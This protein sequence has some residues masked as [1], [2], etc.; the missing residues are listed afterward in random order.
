MHDSLRPIIILSLVSI[1]GA[2]VAF[3]FQS[4]FSRSIEATT[5]QAQRSA[6]QHVLPPGVQI[7]DAFGKNPL[8]PRYWIG[9]KDSATV[10]YAFPAETR[11]FSGAVNS[12]VG[13]D[14]AGI[15]LGVRLLASSGM[16]AQGMAVEDFIPKNSL[17][18]RM[19]GKK[20]AAETWFAEQFAGTSVKKPFVIDTLE[21]G[22]TIAAAEKGKRREANMVSAVSGATAST[23]AMART[24]QKTAVTFL[25]SVKVAAR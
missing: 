1:A 15:I 8:P 22:K 13:I 5:E 20:D 17:L 2:T 21:H 14:T 6:V 7:V 19:S 4:L 24:I 18:G 23:Q 12:L 25:L 9:K 10:A 16:P 11:G 3:F